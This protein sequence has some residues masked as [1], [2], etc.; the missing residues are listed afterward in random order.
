[1][2]PPV[3][4]LPGL[5]IASA[6]L[7]YISLLLTLLPLFDPPTFEIFEEEPFD[8]LRSEPEEAVLSTI[9]VKFQLEPPLAELVSREL[10][11]LG[12]VQPPGRLKL[13]SLE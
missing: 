6:S 7:V 1:M 5:A 10:S 3:P 4:S 12:F 9:L 13:V 8:K 11:A 2:L